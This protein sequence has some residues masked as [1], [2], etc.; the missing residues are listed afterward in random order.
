MFSD[1]RRF[2]KEEALKYG[3]WLLKNMWVSQHKLKT[4][5]ALMGRKK[6]N[7]FIG[8][9]TYELSDLESEWNKISQFPAKFAEYS[10]IGGNRTGGFESNKT[11]N[12]RHYHI[13]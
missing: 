11:E 7:G 1:F 6:A 3:K 13:A 10:N 12:K 8:W 2:S 5:L 9:A 4:C